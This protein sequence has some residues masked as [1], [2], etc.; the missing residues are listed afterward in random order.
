MNRM[1][2][3]WLIVLATATAVFV[4]ARVEAQVFT[5]RVDVTIE[6]ATG[7]RVPGVTVELAGPIGQVQI[8]DAQGQA[9]FLNL[10]VG[11]YSI[12]ASLPGFNP[13]TNSDVE[14]A[15]GAAT[16]LAVKLMAAGTAET[17]TVVAATSGIDLSR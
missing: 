5:G 7:G 3:L 10:P 9:H 2:R 13:Y 12:K 16:P 6:D 4:E 17:V 1:L 11:T 15:A 14:V 8:A